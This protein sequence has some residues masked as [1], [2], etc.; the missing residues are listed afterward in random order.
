VEA[1]D[2]ITLVQLMA[3]ALIL[4]YASFT[5]WKTRRAK[6]E[7]WLALSVVGIVLLPLQVMD[8]KLPLGA[9]LVL[10]PILAILSDIYLDSEGENLWNR[11][12]P[13]AKYGVAVASIVILAWFWPRDQDSAHLLAIPVMMLVIVLMYMLDI[14][15][16]GADAKALIALSI[17]FPY[18]P[19][20]G[21]F[22]MLSPENWQA[23][24]V[25]PFSFVILINAAII[26]ALLPIAFAV[27]NISVREFE[28][29]F[30]FLGYRMDVDTARSKFVWLMERIEDGKLVRY[31][32][33]KRDEDLESELDLLSKA[34]HKRVWIT[35]KIPFIIP[36]SISLIFS[37]IVGNLLLLIVPL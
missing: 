24:I 19:A 18:Y 10:V 2:A 34:G 33:P 15:R 7:L 9:V 17:I 20:I 35:P 3:S 4:G 28:Y 30:G 32:R 5:D 6:N 1:A 26:V 37:V 8:L 21:S 27:K 13:Y 36:I 16:G 22:P 23:Q 29:P 12:A 25:F 11:A 31:T 14:V